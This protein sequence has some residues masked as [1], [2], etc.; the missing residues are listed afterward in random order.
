[1]NYWLI[2]SEPETYSWA[3]MKSDNITAWDGVR[4]YQARNFIMKMKV[5][6]LCYFYHSGKERAIVGIAEVIKEAY[7]D[8]SDESGKFYMMDVRYKEDMSNPVTLSSIKATPELQ[9]LLLVR[10]SRLSVMPVSSKNWSLIE[11][12]SSS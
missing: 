5:G 9:D 10:H 6:D 12:L 4:N 11:S 1:M 8:P 7:K 2:K 3:T